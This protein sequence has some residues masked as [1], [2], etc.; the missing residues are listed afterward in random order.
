MPDQN[1]SKFQLGKCIMKGLHARGMIFQEDFEFFFAPALN[2]QPDVRATGSTDNPSA[3]LTPE[4]AAESTQ[5]AMRKQIEAFQRELAAVQKS[6]GSVP[7]PAQALK[8]TPGGV[9]LATTQPR[10]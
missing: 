3:G 9:Q 1:R 6:A 2:A 7:K 10:A 4:A 8:R 5:A